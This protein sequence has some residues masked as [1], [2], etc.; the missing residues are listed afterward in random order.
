[1]PLKT[2]TVERSDL[3]NTC[4][5]FYTNW[6]RQVKEDMK[7]HGAGIECTHEFETYGKLPPCICYSPIKKVKR[8]GR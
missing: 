2:K 4:A 8:Q 6:E 7:E 1:L 5:C 3:C